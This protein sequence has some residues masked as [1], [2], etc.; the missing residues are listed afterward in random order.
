MAVAV[1]AGGLVFAE[2]QLPIAILM[3]GT[4]VGIAYQGEKRFKWAEA[5]IFRFKVPVVIIGFILVYFAVKNLNWLGLGIEVA[6]LLLLF[7]FFFISNGE[8]GKPTFESDPSKVKEL[9][10]KMKSC[11]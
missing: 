11:C 7:Y 2:F 5:N 4:V 10:E 8:N 3:G 6:I 9:E 1:L